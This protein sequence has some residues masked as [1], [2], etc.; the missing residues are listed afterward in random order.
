MA[1][2]GSA[3]KNPVTGRRVE[4]ERRLSSGDARLKQAARLA[5][6][7]T[8]LRL[9]GERRGRSKKEL[10][11]ELE[12]SVKTVERTLMVLELAGI[13]VDCDRKSG[14]WRLAENC[15][16]PPLPLPAAEA[17]DESRLLA[18]RDGV[19]RQGASTRV[20][21]R[22]VSAVLNRSDRALVDAASSLVAA[23][24]LQAVDAFASCDVL[25]DIQTALATRRKLTIRYASPYAG[26]M[27]E[28]MV[29]P[30]RLCFLRSAWYLIAKPDWSPDPVTLRV[31]RIESVRITPL[32]AVIPDAFSLERYL[33][34]A[35]SAF[36]GEGVHQVRLRF[37]GPA[38]ITVTETR[39][40]PTQKIERRDDGN[41]IVTFEVEGL[42]EIVW[43]LM[44]WAPFVTVEHPPM[45]R[46]RLLNE[47]RAGIAANS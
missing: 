26:R 41:T 18:L 47:L 16:L 38:A 42:E 21:V 19:A 31:V 23:I 15:L 12:C 13:P 1:K 8:L 36:R 17:L 34:R 30:Y 14:V 44:S 9:L 46:E 43:W 24:S 11:S 5:R 4:F 32:T 37:A 25:R 10:A 7:L 22:R 29:E 39:W 2:K 28:H 35:W 6:P 45:L 20:L 40:H 3:R 33:G 27:Q